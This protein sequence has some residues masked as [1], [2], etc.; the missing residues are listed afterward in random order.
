[1][2]LLRTTS[3]YASPTDAGAQQDG[4]ASGA[5]ANFSSAHEVLRVSHSLCFRHG[6]YE[7]YSA[8]LT[9]RVKGGVVYSSDAREATWT[10]RHCSFLRSLNRTV[11]STPRLQTVDTIFAIW[12]HDGCSA[13]VPVTHLSYGISPS[14]S[15]SLPLPW[16]PDEHNPFVEDAKTVDSARRLHA[17]LTRLHPW[18]SKISTAY[19]R[20]GPTD[21]SSSHLDTVWA[22]PHSVRG[23]RARLTALSHMY[24]W[25]LNASI[26]G[27][28]VSNSSHPAT[29]DAAT[30]KWSALYGARRVTFDDNFRHKYIVDVGGV[31]A[32]FRTP[33]LL[34][35]NSVVLLQRPYSFWWSAAFANAT[36]SIAPELSD[37]LRTIEKLQADD[38]F[39]RALVKRMHVAVLEGALSDE[40]IAERWASTLVSIARGSG[41]VDGNP[42]TQSLKSFAVWLERGMCD[43]KRRKS[44]IRPRR[45]APCSFQLPPRGE[46]AKGSNRAR[47]KARRREG[48]ASDLRL[49]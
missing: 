9:V 28:R 17:Q 24:P 4:G 38:N 39:A 48:E 47:E 32:S 26:V 30:N 22:T 27:N 12:P 11:S 41:T 23:A 43:F 13:Q 6:I 25:L 8:L 16:M 33:S 2:A 21:G 14:C 15:R 46:R 42:N 44:W 7:N 34:L 45:A 18:Q 29:A 5:D 49:L 10:A 36:L 35:G 40:A 3:S 20:G 31:G 1:M 37:L 19:W